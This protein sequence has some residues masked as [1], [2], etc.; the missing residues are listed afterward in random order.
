MDSG[1]FNFAAQTKSGSVICGSSQSIQTIENAVRAPKRGE[2]KNRIK[3]EW[4]IGG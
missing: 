2:E 1:A 3:K 4:G